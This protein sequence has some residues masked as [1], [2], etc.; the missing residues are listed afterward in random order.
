MALTAKITRILAPSDF[1]LPAE[2]A[3]LLAARLA[4]CLEAALLVL[5]AIPTTGVALQ[6]G[7][8]TGTTLAWARDDL[9][10][11]LR[12]WFETVVPGEVR[13]SLAAEFHVE[14]G[15]PAPVISRAA[16]V[17]GA[18]LIVMATHGRSGLS[19]LLMGSVAESVP[20]T[21]PVPV[22]TLKTGQGSDPLKEVKRILWATDL[23]P[24]SDRA[25]GYALK[26]ADMLSAE[27]SML[28]VV[29]EA[30]VA[31]PHDMQGRPPAG[32]LGR[33]LEP[34]DRELERR[35]HQA[36][37][38]GLSARRKVTIGTAAEAIAAEAQAAQTDLIVMGTHGRTGLSHILL[39]SV[40]EAVIRTAP[41]PVLAVQVKGQGKPER[42]NPRA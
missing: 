6:I 27:V 3:C 2:G 37:A 7:G 21:A 15:D 20:R 30:E 1:S 24:A 40:A 31:V 17:S 11:R 14:V 29:S 26:L 38:L 28:H 13:G 32:W 10:K 4:N 16:N 36:E 22:L 9:R 5:H 23:S 33:Y 39:G 35:Q 8:G 12:A 25:W 42:P 18:D 19:H 41:C 34:L